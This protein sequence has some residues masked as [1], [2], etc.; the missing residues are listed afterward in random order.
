MRVLLDTNVL[1]RAT[2][3]Y[4]K[5]Q[6]LEHEAAMTAPKTNT[7]SAKRRA[8]D[9][10]IAAETQLAPPDLPAGAGAVQPQAVGQRVD[11][12]STQAVGIVWRRTAFGAELAAAIDAI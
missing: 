8:H 7:R 1:V 4:S 3:H 10:R 12:V 9:E 11:W 5:Y 6:R 2:G